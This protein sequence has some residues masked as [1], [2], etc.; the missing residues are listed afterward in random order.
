LY[1]KATK[2]IR[3]NRF[4]DLQTI[5]NDMHQNVSRELE[6]KIY[7]EAAQ[8]LERMGNYEKAIGFLTN[9]IYSSPDSIKWKLWLIASR[10][11]LL[12]G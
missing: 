7:I 10:L 9:A 5:L 12:M 8:T 2:E 3:E 11:Q 6:W 1:E 4:D